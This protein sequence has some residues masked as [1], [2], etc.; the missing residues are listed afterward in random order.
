MQGPDFTCRSDRGEGKL[1]EAEN[2]NVMQY[3]WAAAD[4]RGWRPA[5]EDAYIAGADVAG[6]S[7]FAVFDG[8]GG[9]QA[10]QAAEK[11]LP[12]LAARVL[13]KDCDGATASS[14]QWAA[15][16]PSIVHTLD[17]ELLTGC[18]PSLSLGKFLLQTYLHPLSGTGSTSVIMALVMPGPHVV[19][20]NTGDS[21]VVLCRGGKAVA[22][23]QDHKPEDKEETTRIIKAGGQ[24]IKVGPCHR[25]DG[26]LNLS[27]ALGDFGF[28]SNLRLP[29]HQQKIIC[30]PD[31]TT[32]RLQKGDEFLLL[33]CDGI[34]ERM[35]RQMAVTFVRDRLAQGKATT[36]VAKELC[37]ACCARTGN[38]PGTDNETVIIVRLEPQTK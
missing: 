33:A 4:M 9:E 12:N 3:T 38:E 21:R 26:N 25:V 15:R 27:R 35:D 20:A 13:A 23:S 30:T 32:T 11:I 36:E 18:M 34:F 10:S 22:L 28:K 7:L 37:W 24:V 29:P 16:L 17:D 14:D 31:V 2:G 19:V 8:H 6:A 5:M 1:Q